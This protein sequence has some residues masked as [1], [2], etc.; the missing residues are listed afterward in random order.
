MIIFVDFSSVLS[1]IPSITYSLLIILFNSIY[2]KIA[3]KLTIWENHRYRYI[4]TC[5]LC[6]IEIPRD[7]HFVRFPTSYFVFPP[8]SSFPAILFRSL[9]FSHFLCPFYQ[10]VYFRTQEQHDTHVTAKLVVFEFVN[11]FIA[12]FYT[13]FYLQ[14]LK[15]LK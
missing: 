15:S 11:T 12:L 9:I 4:V 3:R 5:Q 6:K 7:R 2:L 10:F 1:N 14:D 8:F 13:G